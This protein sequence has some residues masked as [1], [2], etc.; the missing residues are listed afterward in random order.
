LKLKLNDRYSITSSLACPEVINDLFNDDEIVVEELQGGMGNNWPAVLV[1]DKENV[2]FSQISKTFLTWDAFY[3]LEKEF[4]DRA[5]KSSSV[6]LSETLYQLALVNN[7]FT[8]QPNTLLDISYV[9]DTINLISKS[10]VVYSESTDRVLF[11]LKRKINMYQNGSFNDIGESIVKNSELFPNIKQGPLFRKQLREWDNTLKKLFILK[12][13]SNPSVYFVS[14]QFFWHVLLFY[15]SFL[16]L[17]LYV[18]WQQ[19]LVITKNDV[20]SSIQIIEKHFIHDKNI[21]KFWGQGR[22]GH[23]D[24]S[25]DS[26]FKFII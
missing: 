11:F 9:K 21:F 1:D 16:K 5:K 20:I 18:K 2:C 15:F 6:T 19:N 12:F 7:N 22:R 4:I 17:L 14:I 3:Y 24:F 25:P 23:K 13:F 26:L 8:L 10:K